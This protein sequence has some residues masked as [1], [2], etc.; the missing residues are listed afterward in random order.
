MGTQAT[1]LPVTYATVVAAD[2]V[3]VVEQIKRG[4]LSGASVLAGNVLESTGV[5]CPVGPTGGT[6]N[7][8]VDVTVSLLFGGTGSVCAAIGDG[9]ITATESAG[10]VT[11]LHVGGGITGGISNACNPKNLGGWFST[12]GAAIGP[13]SASGATGNRTNVGSVGIFGFGFGFYSG[14]TYTWTQTSH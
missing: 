13:Y 6:L 7:A 4:N 12:S 9:K 2:C 14:R 5:T 1:H 8:C 11:G 3:G 10:W